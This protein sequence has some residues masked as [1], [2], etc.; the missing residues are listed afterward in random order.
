[1]AHV[2]LSNHE[3]LK[4]CVICVDV[5]IPSLSSSSTSFI[6][7]VFAVY[8]PCDPGADNLSPDFWTC[9]TDV[10]WESKTSWSLFSDLNAT[11]AAFEHAS[12]KALAQHTFNEFLHNSCGTDLWQQCPDHNR[13]VDWTCH[14]WHSTGGGNI[15]DCVVIS[16]C[17]LLDSEILTDPTWVPG[18][19]HRAIKVKSILK[20]LVPGHATASSMPFIPFRPLPP[21]WIKYPSRDDKYKFTLFADY[22]DHLVASNSASFQTKITSNESYIERYKLLI[23]LIE[24]AAVNTF[25]QNKPYRFIERW[26]I[27]P[28]IR[29]LVALIRHLGGAISQSKGDSWQLSYG[30]H[31]TFDLYSAQFLLLDD[32]HLKS[33]TEYLVDARCKCHRELYAAKKAEILE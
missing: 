23:T 17:Y 24:H 14:G 11:V 22:V 25:G 5:V 33:V 20:S 1:M 31:K 15:I 7:C 18:S 29:E 28:H 16:G 13:F 19:E 8:A 9:L 10:V 32:L 2:L 6:H 21:L 4:G 26:V 3:P 30:S 27:S 12:D